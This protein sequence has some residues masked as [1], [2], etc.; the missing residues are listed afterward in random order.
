MCYTPLYSIFGYADSALLAA[1]R[2]LPYNIFLAIMHNG[3]DAETYIHTLALLLRSNSKHLTEQ[4]MQ[5]KPV[6]RYG[7]N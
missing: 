3:E 1:V 4:H 5:I 2:L 7:N 6:R